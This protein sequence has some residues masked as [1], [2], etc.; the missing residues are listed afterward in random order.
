M[1]G[2]TE[3]DGETKMFHFTNTVT[4]LLLVD[5]WMSVW[6]TGR[7]TMTGETKVLREIPVPMLLYAPQI[8]SGL[9]WD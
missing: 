6:S 3:G 7:I 8:P 4:S 5:E 2:K 9:A 1:T